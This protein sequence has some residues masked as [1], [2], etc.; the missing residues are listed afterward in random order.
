MDKERGKTAYMKVAI[1]VLIFIS[2]FFLDAEDSSTPEFKNFS[3]ILDKKI[4]ELGW[5]EPKTDSITWEYYRKSHKDNPLFFKIFGDNTKNSTLF[6]GG[7]HGDEPAPVYILIR[8]AIFLQE[9]P[10]YYKDKQIVIAPLVNPDGFLVST[11]TNARGVDINRNLPTTN[12]QHDAFA[13]WKNKEKGW[14]KKFPGNT[15]GSENETK[16]QIALIKRFSPQKIISIHSPLG[17]YD[18]DGATSDLDKLGQWIK[19]I[20]KETN[21]PVKK[22]RVYPGSLGNYAGVEH[23]IFTITLELPSSKPSL[24]DEYFDKFQKSFIKLMELQCSNLTLN[25]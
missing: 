16:F 6:L 8:L 22:Y 5:K 25:P 7:V 23:K 21:F 4:K 11:R 17:F 24:A 18:Y 12:W 10:E 9:H 19:T 14:K 1:C 15:P 20:S 13:E 2:C 3:K